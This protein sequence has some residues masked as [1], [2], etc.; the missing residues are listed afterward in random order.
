M[1]KFGAHLVG[2]QL[3]DQEL[4]RVLHALQEITIG[5]QA[6]HRSGKRRGAVVHE[7]RIVRVD[8]D[9]ESIVTVDDGCTGAGGFTKHHTLVSKR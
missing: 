7:E 5:H 6:T 4:G 9:G 8:T 1:Q 2:G 3:R